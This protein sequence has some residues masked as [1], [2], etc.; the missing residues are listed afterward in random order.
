M[1]HYSL[2]PADNDQQQSRAVA[3]KLHVY[4]AVVNFNSYGS[5]EIYS[6]IAR[7]SLR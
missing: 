2:L 3:G 4:D 6:G 7:F 1:I 5:I